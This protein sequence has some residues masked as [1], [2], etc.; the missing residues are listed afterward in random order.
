MNLNTTNQSTAA[1]ELEIALATLRDSTNDTDT[2]MSTK[3]TAI[4]QKMYITPAIASKLQF[5]ATD[6]LDTIINALNDACMVSLCAD[7]SEQRKIASVT[8]RTLGDNRLVDIGLSQTA[9]DISKILVGAQ[10]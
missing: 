7:R 5:K 6:S 2:I 4:F 3:A 9:A 1:E 10:K 8:I